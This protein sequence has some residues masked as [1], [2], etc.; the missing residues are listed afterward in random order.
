[1]KKRLDNILVEK[2]YFE[3][4]QKAKAMIMA[5][6]VIVN[7]HA[8]TKAGTLFDEDKIQIRIKEKLKYVS[9]GGLKLE[10]AIKEFNI[11]FNQK[12]VLDIGASTGGFTDCSL[13]HGACFVYSV[14]VGT[15]QLCYE[16]CNNE[17]VLKL[18]NMHINKLE[19]KDLIKGLPDIIVT[20]VSFISLTKIAEDINRFSNIGTE[21]IILIKPQFEVGK[22]AIGKN[23]VV[24]D[25][26]SR[27]YA[28]ET[29]KNTY[30]KLGFKILN[31][32]ES[33]ITG[34]KGNIEYLM[35]ARKEEEDE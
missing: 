14:D 20:D 6:N 26:D 25:Q 4:R 9:R 35:Y 5:A 16:L 19:K 32:C 2:G 23:G 33:P 13:K 11:D 10:K 7:D 28:I 27:D 31:I 12:L 18:E 29:V 30:K 21:I 17:K 34:A 15:N 8:I 24:K 1:M 22:D 3:T